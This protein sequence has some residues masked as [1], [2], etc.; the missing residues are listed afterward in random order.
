LANIFLIKG[1]L[2]VCAFRS[3]KNFHD[4]KRQRLGFRR[5]KKIN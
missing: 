5:D 2:F 4:E 1:C 3:F